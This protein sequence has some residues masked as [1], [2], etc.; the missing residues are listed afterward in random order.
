MVLLSEALEVCGGFLDRRL[1]FG[2]HLEIKRAVFLIQ[3]PGP[4]GDDRCFDLLDRASIPFPTRILD[5]HNAK[6]VM[7]VMVCENRAV[8]PHRR[9]FEDDPI[10]WLAGPQYWVL[11]RYAGLRIH[12]GIADF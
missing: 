9:L 11:L 12:R 3:L 6:I 1:L 7:N 2:P 5:S 4:D 8:I 10:G